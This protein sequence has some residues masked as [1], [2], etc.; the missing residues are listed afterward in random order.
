MVGFKSVQCQYLF[1][2]RTLRKSSL[3]GCL[4][5]RKIGECLRVCEP[6]SLSLSVTGLL[7][8]K[9]EIRSFLL[10]RIM[11]FP[12]KLAQEEVFSDLSWTLTLNVKDH[13]KLYGAPLG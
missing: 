2:I 8:S 4:D 13:I 9:L 7:A 12:V 3:L 5:G 6:W 10:L 1:T 11:F